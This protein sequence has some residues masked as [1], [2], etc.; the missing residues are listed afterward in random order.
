[1]PAKT[2]KSVPKTKTTTSS[3]K[4]PRLFGRRFGKPTMFVALFALVGVTALLVGLAASPTGKIVNAQSKECLENFF[5]RQ[6]N[7]NF[8]STYPCAE[9]NQAQQWTLASD[10]SIRTKDNYCLQVAGN[11]TKIGTR[12]WLWQCNG[13]AGQKWKTRSNGTIRNPNSGLCLEATA[14]DTSLGGPN[15]LVRRCDASNKRQAWS[16]PSAIVPVPIPTPQPTNPPPAT[17]IPPPTPPAVWKP[18]QS[19]TAWQWQLTGAVNETVLDGVSGPKMY[20]IDMWDATPD[21]ISRLQ[22]KG[23]YVVCYVESGDWAKGRPDAGDYASVILGRSISGFPD[24]KYV[25]I[26]ALDGPAGPTGKTL[27]Q[28][29]QARLELARSKGCQGIEP[30]LDDLHTYSTGFSISIDQM[31]NYNKAIIEMGHA[32]GMSVG[33]KNGASGGDFEKRMLDAGADWALNEECNQYDE[34]DGYSQFIAAGKPVFQ[35]EYL[36]N[37][38]KPYSGANGTCAKDNAANFDGIVKDSSSQLS[39]LPRIACR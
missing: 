23:I 20:D 30:D 26:T 3:A 33:L 15:I 11:S 28:I 27:R 2:K 38:R 24:E 9:S 16:V 22:A 39:A 31:V 6:I 10:S 37:Q 36:D 12:V 29:M 8:I 13:S 19:G 4:L 17:D 25:N 21:L 18:L 5:N 14:E 34:C 32:R 7:T 35:V 1:M